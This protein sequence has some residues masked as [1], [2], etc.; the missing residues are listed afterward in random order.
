M[1][2]PPPAFEPRVHAGERAAGEHGRRSYRRPLVGADQFAD[3]QDVAGHRRLQ[4]V[5]L[6]VGVDGQ[7]GVEGEELEVVVVEAVAER[8]L[9]AEVAAGLGVVGALDGP[10]ELAQ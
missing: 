8:G 3:G 5:E 7:L 6:G 10:A 1:D 2:A 9:G 4:V